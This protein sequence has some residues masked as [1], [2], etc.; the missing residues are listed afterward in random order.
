MELILECAAKS[1]ALNQDGDLVVCLTNSGDLTVYARQQFVEESG[2][3]IPTKSIFINKVESMRLAEFLLRQSH[4]FSDMY[5]ALKKAEQF[6]D[7]IMGFYGEG[8]QVAEWHQNRD[9][10]PL[11]NFIKNN[12]DGDE[13]ELIRKVLDKVRCGKH[14]L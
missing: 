12:S 9:L 13:L 8:L 7:A 14:E 1:I 6:I 10:E 2:Q 3:I 4:L 11:D 5:E